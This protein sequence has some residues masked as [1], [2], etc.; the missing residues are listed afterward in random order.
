MQK[1]NNIDRTHLVLQDS[2]TKNL[3]FKLDCNKVAAPGQVKVQLHFCEVCKKKLRS[4]QFRGKKITSVTILT[5]CDF[6]FRTN[7]SLNRFTVS[8]SIPATLSLEITHLWTD[9]K[10]T[11]WPGPDPII[12]I[13]VEIRNWSHHWTLTI[14]IHHLTKTL[15]RNLS[16]VKIKS[17]LRTV[18][19]YAY[20]NFFRSI[21]IWLKIGH[22]EAT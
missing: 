11:I 8:I 13:S 17:W 21:Y 18:Q 19:E 10:V 7:M 20:F 16:R 15:S 12:K 14:K 2:T 3:N 6:W 9:E 22:L 5:I 4:R 1:L